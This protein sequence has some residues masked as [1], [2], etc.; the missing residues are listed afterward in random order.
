M[1]TQIAQLLISVAV[2]FF[3]YL[4]LLRFHLQWL[5]SPF[6]NQIGQFVV[7]TTNWIVLP[8]R[9]VI[10][11]LAGLDLATLGAAWLLQVA[12]LFLGLSLRGWSLGAAWGPE[13]A[14]LLGVALVDLLRYSL[15]LLSF[16]VVLQAVLSWINPYTPL[17]P[18]LNAATRPFLRPLQRHLPLVANI[19]LSPLV[20]LVA[21]QVLLI[22]VWDLRALVG[23]FL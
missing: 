9:R 11:S 23:S 6:R 1:F 14:A 17:E 5:R 4:L 18:V 22:P 8:A 2:G 12:G 21:L 10:P 16:A 19:D 15:Y 3:V 7:A 20:L 13:L